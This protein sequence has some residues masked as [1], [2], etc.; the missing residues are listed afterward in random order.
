MNLSVTLLASLIA[1]AGCTTPPAP[2]DV[3][4]PVVVGTKTAQYEVT[5]PNQLRLAPGVK[6]SPTVG[7]HG[8]SGFVVY[9]DNNVG[10]YMACGCNAPSGR[11][12][13][14][15]ENDN[16][17][18]PSCSGSCIDDQGVDRGCA[19]LGPI[20]G[21][22]KD[23]WQIIK[24]KTITVGPSAEPTTPAHWTG[25]GT[26]LASGGDRSGERSATRRAPLL[27]KGGGDPSGD[28]GRVSGSH[29]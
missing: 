27:P 11:D 13:C 9:L 16:P 7:P 4:K 3:W 10:G 24:G 17:A 5:A 18:H 23:P 19:I 8:Q 1:L 22:P 15:T 6:Y 26:V 29:S 21:P 2:K 28:R 20:I 12:F 14:K 25:R